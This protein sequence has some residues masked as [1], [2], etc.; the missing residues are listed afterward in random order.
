MYYDLHIKIDMKLVINLYIYA[1]Q[2]QQRLQFVWFNKRNFTQ[3]PPEGIW[4]KRSKIYK[5]I[6][7]LGFEI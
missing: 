7:E 5:Y 2:K 1:N 6:L 3:L 4:A